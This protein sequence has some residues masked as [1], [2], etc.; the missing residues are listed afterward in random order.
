MATFTIMEAG[1]GLH[2]QYVDVEANSL[3]GATW[4][5]RVR[6]L[7]NVSEG[8]VILPFGKTVTGPD[9]PVTREWVTDMVRD[10]D[11]L[12]R[13]RLMRSLWEIFDGGDLFRIT[14]VSEGEIRAEKVRI[15]REVIHLPEG[16]WESIWTPT[17][18]AEEVIF[19]L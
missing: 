6:D 4:L 11:D 12:H 18:E 2:V 15:S 3:G 9:G 8:E 19:C 7:L 5:L 14:S 10:P 17:G 13:D 1:F 16:R